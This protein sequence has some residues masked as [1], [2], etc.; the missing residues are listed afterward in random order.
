M[1]SFKEFLTAI[2]EDGNKDCNFIKCPKLRKQCKK[3]MTRS[4][5]G[6]IMFGGLPA[7]GGNSGGAG[8]A[9][10]GAGGGA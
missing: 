10:A 8:G 6:V 9:G 7:G 2:N 4:K 5:G 1:I 3:L